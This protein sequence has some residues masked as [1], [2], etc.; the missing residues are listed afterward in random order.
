MDGSGKSF[1]VSRL[2]EFLDQ[3]D[4][5][6]A[7]LWARGGNSAVMLRLKAAARHLCGGAGGPLR[8]RG[9]GEHLRP[10]WLRRTW[11]W[12]VCADLLLT[13]L[14]RVWPRLLA[15]RVVL[16]DRHTLDA[17]V[18]LSF[19]LDEPAPR[20][21]WSWQVLERLTP[22]P[23]LH[24]LLDLPADVAL[25]RKNLEGDAAHVEIRRRRYL[26]YAPQS[27]IIVDSGQPV[28]AVAAEIRGIALRTLMER[29][30]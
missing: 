4:V 21:R 27:V 28:E 20:Q 1:H 8:P 22:T 7:T 18:D 9:A 24:L 11:P 17:A 13:Y 29:I 15:R 3:C 23:D 5:A 14:V 19:R 10:G 16:C 30:S 6:S 2:H 12:I 25:R 26:A